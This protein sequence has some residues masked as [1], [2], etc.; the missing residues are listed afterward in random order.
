MPVNVEPGIRQLLLKLHLLRGLEEPELV[1]LLARAEVES[2]RDG[3][4]ILREGDQGTHMYVLLGGQTMI[5]R[6]AA[7]VQ[8][9]LKQAGP[10]E[11][12]G[13]MALVENL[14]RSASVRAVGACKLLRIDGA[15]IDELP[16]VGAKIYRNIAILLSKRLRQA[17]D[18]VSLG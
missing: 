18:L 5:V 14:P 12:L 9:I 2:F 4:Y 3:D 16:A 11:C 17:N 7:G 8:K 13:E 10:G 15:A 6:G 1:D